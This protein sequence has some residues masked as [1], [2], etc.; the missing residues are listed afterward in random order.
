[1]AAASPNPPGDERSVVEEVINEA[2][3]LGLPD[4][5]VYARIPT[6]PNALIRIGQG[7][8]HL[9][10]VAHTDT[11]PPG[12]R[13]AWHSDPFQLSANGDRL[14]G[15]GVADMKAAIAAALHALERYSRTPAETGS[16]TL[17]L[18]ADEEAGSAYGL[19][20][21]LAEDLIAADA[22]VVLEPAAASE[23]HCWQH[24]FVAQ[25]GSCVCWLVARGEPGHS[26][27]PVARERRASFAFTSA[28]TALIHADPFADLA[29]PVDG[30]NPTLNVA[31]VVQGGEVPFAHPQ[32]LR[33]A[34]EVRVV[35]GMTTEMVLDR[36]RHVIAAVGL[37]D[38]VDIELAET[39]QDWIPPGEIVTDEKLLGAAE[40][41][42]R[43]VFGQS[44]TP[45]VYPAGTDSS[46]LDNHGIPAL[47]A[48]GPG[49]LAVAHRPNE[50]L[51]ASELS[52]ASELFEAVIRSY[53]SG[54]DE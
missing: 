13:A 38:A 24:L 37:A 12:D 50:W 31:T 32:T 1:V 52:R 43:S 7:D 36:L 21:L 6:R 44:P 51:Q 49:S 5:T 14:V 8:P 47:P 41:A 34:L 29:H 17:L 45:A 18:V 46:H 54:A 4:P 3:A 9:L 35:Q 53:L 27:I 19:Q 20:W 40:S 22:A 23:G 42:W 48:F 2:R 11:M 16:V 30:T 28:L 26:G 25:R 15:L 10:L 33:A 39:P